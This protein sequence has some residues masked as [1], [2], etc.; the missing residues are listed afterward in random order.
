ML[1]NLLPIYLVPLLILL[2]QFTIHIFATVFS[3]YFYINLTSLRIKIEG[4]NFTMYYSACLLPPSE[5]LPCSIWN[6]VT[7]LKSCCQATW[8]TTRPIGGVIISKTII[9]VDSMI[10]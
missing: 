2:A 6:G 10:V 7:K 5:T 9:I 1:Y 8:T 4:I 3:G